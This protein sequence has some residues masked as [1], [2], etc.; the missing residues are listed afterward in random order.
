MTP[1][2]RALRLLGRKARTALEL[3]QALARAKVEPVE[4]AEVLA[5]VRELG[6]MDDLEVARGRARTL[7]ARGEAP[8]L[9]A[10]KLEAQGVAAADAQGAIDEAREGASEAE[11]A[12]RALQKRLRGRKPRD[13]RER[14]RVF[15]ALVARGHRPALVA[16]ALELDQQGQEGEDGSAQSESDEVDEA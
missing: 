16:Q 8:R 5:R 12:A 6:Y 3:D 15:R 14:Q 10:R 1:L 9:A 4:R 11:L 13:E 7:L 2:D